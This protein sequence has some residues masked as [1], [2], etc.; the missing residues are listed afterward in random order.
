[1]VV[2][3]DE[4][5]DIQDIMECGQAFRYEL[6]DNGGYRIVAFGKRLN[7]V[8]TG[9]TIEVSCGEMEWQDTWCDYFD[10]NRDYGLVKEALIEIDERLASYIDKKPGIRILRQEVFEMVM[11]FIISQNKSMPQIKQLV[12]RISEQYG[13]QML[14]EKGVYYAFP[15]PAQ[16]EDVTEQDFRDLKTGFRGPYLADAVAKIHSG[17]LDLEA[18]RF[19]DTQ[20][21][22]DQL[23]TIKGVGP[24]VAN[25]ILLFGYG[26]MD[27]FP[28]DVW[29]KRA[30]TQLYFP[31]KQASDKVMLKKAEDLFGDLQGIAQQYLF[32]GT[33]DR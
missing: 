12:Q 18:L 17:Q 10:L 22:R 1:M 30:M 11:T 14:D 6:L 8:Q 33:V 28:L 5:F 9:L 25:C 13:S 20:A 21:I 23:L 3:V 27:V 24:K 7:I 16:L 31:E 19:M 26:R 4:H 15:T 32:Y 2:C 29:M